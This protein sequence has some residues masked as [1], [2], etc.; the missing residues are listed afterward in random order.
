MQPEATPAG[1][2]NGKGSST[3]TAPWRSALDWLVL[4][5]T[6]SGAAWLIA[7][8][9]LATRTEFGTIAPAWAAKVLALHGGAAMLALV[10]IG[11]W[12]PAHVLPRISRAPRRWTGLLQLGLCAVLMSTGFGL[13]YLADE[14]TR[15]AWSLVH[16]TCGLGW[17]ALLL[18]HRRMRRK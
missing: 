4:T 14:T 18:V 10:A 13:Y 17:P 9:V 6:G 8:R 15:P 2:S 3:P 7:Q 16:W 5:L 1:L 12:L 11:A